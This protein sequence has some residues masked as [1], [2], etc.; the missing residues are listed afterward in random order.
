MKINPTSLK[1][2]SGASGVKLEPKH[3]Q[4]AMRQLGGLENSTVVSIKAVLPS[5]FH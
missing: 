2:D 4:Q 1:V 3:L 5:S